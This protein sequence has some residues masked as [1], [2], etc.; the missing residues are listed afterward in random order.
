[1]RI[2]LP[3]AL[4][5]HR[6]GGF[7]KRFLTELGAEVVLSR[8]TDRALVQDGVTRVPG[9]VCLPIKIVAGHLA[10]LADKVDAVFFP[11]LVWL[12]DRLYGCPKMIGIVDIARMMYGKAPRLIAPAIKGNFFRS[13]IRAGLEINPNPIA[14][15][16]AWFRAAPLLRR[17]EAEPSFPAGERRVAL[18]GHFYNIGDGYISDAIVRGFQERGYRVVTKEELPE[19]VLRSRDGFARNIRWTYERELYNA[20]VNLKDRV[21]GVCTIIS[22]GCG[23]DSLVA[24]FMRQEAERQNLPFLELVIDEHTGTA[25]LLTRIEAFLDLSRRRTRVAA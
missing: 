11:R 18:I 23:P 1:M 22:M 19:R 24:E 3:Q 6:Y 17:G 2:G 12:E 5:Y 13:N 15:L 8:K 9:E 4:L 25:G 16:R 7:W 10:E 21:D 20:F 14:V